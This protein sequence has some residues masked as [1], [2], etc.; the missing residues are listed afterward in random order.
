VIRIGTSG[1]VYK[2]WKGI[3]YP[4]KLP[5]RL[6]F[7]AYAR[8]FDTVEIN[9]TFYRLPAESTFATWRARAPA[10]FTYA[11]KASRFITHV[12]RLRDP[13][14][15]VTRLADRLPALGDRCG[16]ILWQLPPD[17]E[18]DDQ[19]LDGLLAVL[20][21]HWQH[22]IEFRHPSWLDQTVFDK[23][24]AAGVALCIPDHP[25][26]PQALDLTADWTYVRFHYGAVDG[27]YT[28]EQVDLWARR[29]AEWRA[30]GVDVWAYFNNDWHGYAIENAR[31]LMAKLGVA[32]PSAERQLPLSA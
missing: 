4:E 11:V 15:D 17:F 12:R 14:E 2:H 20:P 21:L 22:T 7:D 9:F 13:A 6:W 24:R 25:K 8:S 3:F 30:R 18:R 29:I 28:C 1:W 16:P 32:A 23:L 26:L 19:R 31:E 5:Q 10:G 27:R